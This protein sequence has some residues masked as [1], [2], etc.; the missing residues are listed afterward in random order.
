MTRE[1]EYR[2][3]GEGWD[4]RCCDLCG[5]RADIQH[6]HRTPHAQGGDDSDENL[7]PLCPD[8]H[9]KQSGKGHGLVR[10]MRRGIVRFWT[11]LEQR[12]YRET[13]AAEQSTCET[14]GGI[15][16]AGD[17]LY[18]GHGQCCGACVDAEYRRMYEAEMRHWFGDDWGRPKQSR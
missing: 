9:A 14:C 8:C 3:H 16:G 10:H 11:V 7:Q 5:S 12:E 15:I 17:F 18:T 1:R 4:G 2:R 13:R 6:H